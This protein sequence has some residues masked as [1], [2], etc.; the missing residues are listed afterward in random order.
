MCDGVQVLLDNIES[1]ERA[2][3]F[4]EY[5]NQPDVWSLLAKAQLDHQQV[6][7]AIRSYLKAEDAQLYMEV[8][9]AA[10]AQGIFP[11]LIDFLKMARIKIREAFIDNELIYAFARTKRHSDLE[12]FIASPNAA[13]AASISSRPIARDIWLTPSR[14]CCGDAET[15]SQLS[16]SSGWSMPSQARRVEPFAPAWPI[17]I[18]NFASLLACTQSTTRCHAADCADV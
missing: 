3:E 2:V 6:K 13:F 1:I 11:E 17:C 8:T 4:A 7:E 10:K 9:N 5:W 12:D 16:F 18:P 15:I 14:Y